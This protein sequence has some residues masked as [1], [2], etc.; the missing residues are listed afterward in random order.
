MKKTN[1]IS[2]IILAFIQMINQNMNAQM[3]T[4]K[5]ITIDNTKIA[6][7]EQGKGETVLLLHGWPQTSYV[8]RKVLPELSKN[9][10]VIAV[11]LP[12]LGN[13]D[14]TRSY[15]T[16]NI[17]TLLNGL[18]DSLQIKKF[19]L[20]GHDIGSWVAVAYAMHFESKLITLTVIDAGIPGLI[21]PT[22]FQPENANKIWQFYFHAVD[23]IPEFLTEGKEKEYLSWYF[24]K[25]S[26]I[27]TAIDETDLQIYYSAYKGK[28]KMK[29]GFDYYR[30]FAESSTQNKSFNSTLTIPI[31]AIGGKYAMADQVGIAM[32]KIST[33]VQTETVDFCGHYIP[34]EQPE[35]LVELIEKHINK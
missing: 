10:R 22:V 32:K 2:I 31:L 6:Y 1:K 18:T 23:E 20:V 29:N 9:Y 21:S 27:K 30:A 17:A 12:G 28:K 16:K 25:K 7:Y 24:S 4:E 33:N 34:E 11:D 26:Y 14:T 5:T 19:H 3:P 15:D 13:S 8:W 35:K